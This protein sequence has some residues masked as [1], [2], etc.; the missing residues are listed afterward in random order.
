MRPLQYFTPKMIVSNHDY[1]YNI[2]RLHL[3]TIRLCLHGLAWAG[4]AGLTF[5]QCHSDF[6]DN[7][8]NS[9]LLP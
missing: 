8:S 6:D 5:W 2:V 7:Y 9:K 3:A 4:A 1:I